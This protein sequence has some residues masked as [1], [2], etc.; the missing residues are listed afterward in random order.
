VKRPPADN[1]DSGVGPPQATPAEQDGDS[2]WERVLASSRNCAARLD[3]R[4]HETIARSCRRFSASTS[5]IETNI[6][7]RRK[8]IAAPVTETSAAPVDGG[9][10][11]MGH[12]STALG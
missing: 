3:R 9:G 8:M 5:L 10:R 7:G 1:A 4:S 11:R 2:S 12:L 6:S